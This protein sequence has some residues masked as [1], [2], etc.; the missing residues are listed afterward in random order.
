MLS[1]FFKVIIQ[2]NQ[3][4]KLLGVLQLYYDYEQFVNRDF[5]ND[6]FCI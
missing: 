3:N 6:M 2:I 5:M 1:D 4:Q